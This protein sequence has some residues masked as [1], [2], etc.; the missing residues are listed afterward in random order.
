MKKM[1][2][3]TVMGFN[4]HNSNVTLKI[5]PDALLFHARLPLMIPDKCVGHDG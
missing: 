5:K 2:H 4:V 3:F 1:E